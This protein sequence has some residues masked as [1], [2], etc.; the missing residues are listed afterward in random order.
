ML[1]EI[2]PLADK[3][4]GV[5]VDGEVYWQSKHSFD[6]DFAV[7]QMVKFLDAKVDRHPELRRKGGNQNV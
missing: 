7:S 1:I 5:F 4:Y 2:R 6:C 3:Y